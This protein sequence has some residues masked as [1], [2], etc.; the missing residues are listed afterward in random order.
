MCQL[1]RYSPKWDDNSVSSAV[2]HS[3]SLKLMSIFWLKSRFLWTLL[4]AEF[5][6]RFLNSLSLADW[7]EGA[8]N[9][10][11]L[12][13]CPYRWKNWG[14]E[15]LDHLDK[16]VGGNALVETALLLLPGQRWWITRLFT[17]VIEF[18]RVFDLLCLV[19]FSKL[20]SQQIMAYDPDV[21][22]IKNILGFL[23]AL[24]WTQPFIYLFIFALGDT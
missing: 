9:T 6:F 13:P 7:S 16:A 21:F 18:G 15:P 20:E 10:T 1:L 17:L 4:A 12:T 19:L 11:Y 23:V 14:L 8:Y 22:F 24:H 5:N 3:V 2:T